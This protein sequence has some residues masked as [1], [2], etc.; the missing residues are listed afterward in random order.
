MN[1][2]GVFLLCGVSGFGLAAFLLTALLGQ[3]DK[4]QGSQG[5]AATG[6]KQAPQ[7]PRAQ[8]LLPHPEPPFKGKIGH[9]VKEYKPDFP[10]EVQAPEGA[11]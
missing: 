3:Q 5:T 8:E 4:S 9:T 1:W 10:K 7:S 11:D 6:G 2:A